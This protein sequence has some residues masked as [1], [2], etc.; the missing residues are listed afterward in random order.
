M[1]RRVD[2]PR[3]GDHQ[4]IARL[5]SG[6]PGGEIARFHPQHA[7]AGGENPAQRANRDDSGGEAGARRHRVPRIRR[8][9]PSRSPVGRGQ[10]PAHG[11]SGADRRIRSVGQIDRA[12]LGES[13]RRRSRRHGLFRHACGL[14]PGDRHGRGHRR[15]HRIGAHQPVA[16]RRQRAGDAAFA[17][18]QEVRL[19]D[20]RHH[21][22][23]QRDHLRL[24]EVRPATFHSSKCSRR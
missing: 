11:R 24:R 20:H 1:A 15:R 23:H 13:D 9:D 19:R 5:H 4:R 2:H 17:A 12:R 21:S 22:H 6:R 14:R 7:L 3:R 10:E 8:Q 16:R 18:D